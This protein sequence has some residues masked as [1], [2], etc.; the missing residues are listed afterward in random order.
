MEG[1][2]FR[3]AVFGGY[4]ALKKK[5][6]LF[7][8]SACLLLSACGNNAAVDPTPTP[9]GTPGGT[10]GT[11][12]PAAT[13][14][15]PA[16][17]LRATPDGPMLYVW[18]HDDELR[19]VLMGAVENGVLAAW[20]PDAVTVNGTALS[21]FAQTVQPDDE[22]GAARVEAGF[23]FSLWNSAYHPDWDVQCSLLPIGSEV[24]VFTEKGSLG[25]ATIESVACFAATED[26]ARPSGL[27]Q[28]AAGQ[29]L[30]V[31]GTLKAQG[32]FGWDAM[33]FFASFAS[34]PGG[35]RS[36]NPYIV[37]Q[38]SDVAFTAEGDFLNDGTTQTLKVNAK[39]AATAEFAYYHFPAQLFRGESLLGQ[40]DLN[41]YQYS[42]FG[43]MAFVDLLGNGRQK[44]IW[45]HNY[46]LRVYDI[47]PGSITQEPVG[48]I[49]GMGENAMLQLMPYV[50]LV[51]AGEADGAK[52]VYQIIPGG[53]NAAEYRLLGGAK[54]GALFGNEKNSTLNNDTLDA[55]GNDDIV[56]AYQ[57]AQPM[58]AAPSVVLRV[59]FCNAGDAID[60]YN[61]KGKVGT[62]VVQ[63]PS[64]WF[65]DAIA[66][67]EI[68]G[69]L[70]DA[71]L[72]DTKASGLLIGVGTGINPIPREVLVE[73][74]STYTLFTADIDNDGADETLRWEPAVSIPAKNAYDPPQHPINIARGEESL[75]HVNYVYDDD[76]TQPDAIALMDIDG[77]GVFELILTTKGHNAYTKVYRWENGTFAETEL[78]H[79]SSSL[80]R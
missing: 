51:S 54:R 23:D 69:T 43:R 49:T 27:S 5:L 65:S 79:Q 26:G 62:A 38:Q 56:Y 34:A 74:H 25:R 14:H 6:S 11:N 70:K 19:F 20:S 4:F 17:N 10:A 9:D 33:M 22:N 30:G 80:V 60:V 50:P 7:L 3:I 64:M 73:K 58:A 2:S 45:L 15:A 55:R 71:Q 1:F 32:L 41:V 77:D 24:D 36:D 47:A 68:T 16:Q 59:P 76:Y 35:G 29:T 78:G 42:T 37:M 44:L 8:L 40:I 48:C 18:R 39:Q 46:G 52:G 12:D 66:A 75:G 28:V 31:Y 67:F 53:E 21:A 61:Q 63:A 57:S 13:S 72:G